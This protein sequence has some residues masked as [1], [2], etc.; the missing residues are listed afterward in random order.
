ME[1]GTDIRYVVTGTAVVAVWPIKNRIF[2]KLYLKRCF[3]A[4]HAKTINLLL[5]KDRK[6]IQRLQ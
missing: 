2:D 1:F 6:I 4:T 3:E 5:I